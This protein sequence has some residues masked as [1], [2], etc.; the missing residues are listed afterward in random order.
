MTSDNTPTPSQTPSQTPT[1]EE[2]AAIVREHQAQHD[3][4]TQARVLQGAGL[5][6]LAFVTA[7]NAGDAALAAEECG[8]WLDVVHRAG[9]LG[10]LETAADVF[11]RHVPHTH[12]RVVAA[13]HHDPVIKRTKC[14]VE[15]G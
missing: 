5:D 8:A 14:R 2:A 10:R 13:T 1:P 4:A 9:H 6:A 11:W 12:M 15:H 3:D 7:Q